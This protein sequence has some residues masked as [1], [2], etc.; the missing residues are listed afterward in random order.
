MERPGGEVSLDS[1]CLEVREASFA[2]IADRWDQ[3]LQQCGSATVF[4]SCAWQQVWWSRFANG[5]SLALLEVTRAGR[6]VAIAPLMRS[7]GVVSFLGDTDLVDYHDFL[8]AGAESGPV[9]EAVFKHVAAWPEVHTID[10]KSM[11]ADSPTLGAFKTAAGAGQWR[12]EDSFEDVAPGVTLPETFDEYVSGLEKKDR[13]ELRRKLRRLNAAGTVTQD[14]YRSPEEIERAFDE[15]IR[16]VRLSSPE[17]DAF[18]TAE[19]VRFMR[20]AT[21]AL[22]H[23]GMASLL[24]LNLDGRRVASSLSFRLR[25]RSYG[26][27]SGYDP[28]YRQLAVGL[29]NHALALERA[30]AEGVRYFD[31][32]RGSEHYKYDLGARDREIRHVVVRR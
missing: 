29:L 7:Q 27:N 10:L 3:L 8:I 32:M 26:Y 5:A 25:D 9:A 16:L 17:K 12:L 6:P 20:E 23:G 24:M 19:R 11:P 14:D 18:L 21:V 15:F 22:A 31:F 28:E 30:I 2:S 13:H 1:D 4:L